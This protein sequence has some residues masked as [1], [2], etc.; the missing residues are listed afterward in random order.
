M[1]LTLLSCCNPAIAQVAPPGEYGPKPEIPAPDKSWFATLKIPKSVG[2]PEGTRPTAAAGL[3]V[4]ALA[5]HLSH[6]RWLYVLPNGDV[7]VAESDAPP[8]PTSKVRDALQGFVLR[9][10]GAPQLP[11]ADRISLLRPKADGTLAERHLFLQGLR[12]PFGMALIGH[13][14]YVAT[15]DALLK[16][17]YADGDTEIRSAAATV[18]KLPSLPVGHWTRSLLASNDGT[19]LYVGVGSSSNIG[20]N[21]L[22]AET[23]RAAIWEINVGTEQHRIFASG[24]RN[25]VGLAWEPQSGA[26]WVSVNERDGL[27]DHLPPDYMTSVRDGGFY[28]F[29]FSYFGQVDARFQPQDP[30]MVAKSIM[31]DYALGAHTASLGLCWSGSATLPAGFHNGMFVGQHGSWNRATHS[32]YKVIFVPFQDGRPTGMPV[33]VLTGF[34]NEQ[35]QARGRPVG[36]AI[37]SHGALLVADDVGNTVWRVTAEHA[38]ATTAVGHPPLIG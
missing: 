1:L 20:D 17:P 26:L 22:N 27:G 3:T 12:S 13:T 30:A 36:V 15:N 5:N 7:L 38:A 14:L 2:W 33:D 28:G 32:G 25:P 31:P 19:K 9:M 16:F 24:L 23:G 6:P 10:L 11:S 34:L 37:D 4:T 29:P 8:D 18:A 21:G 35:D